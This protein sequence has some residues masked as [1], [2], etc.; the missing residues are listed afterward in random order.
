LAQ[1]DAATLI[2]L[3]ETYIARGSI[4]ISD[5]WRA[6][7]LIP[8][9]FQ[10]L[11]VNHSLYFVDPETGAHTNNIEATWNAIKRG[12]SP[13]NR[14]ERGMEQHLWSFMWKRIHKDDLWGGFINALRNVEYV[15]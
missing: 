6:Y 14:V 12:I 2:P 1:R 10:H 13:R 5:M 7:D 9:H 15:D 8:A 3:I 11:T 4:I